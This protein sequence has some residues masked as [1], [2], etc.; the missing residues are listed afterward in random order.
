MS[1]GYKLAQ[2]EVTVATAGTA[3]QLRSPTSAGKWTHSVE[4]SANPT[5]GGNIYFGPST[6]SSTTIA[7]LA[8]GESVTL[9]G[10]LVNS[11]QTLMDLSEIFIDSDNDGESAFITFIVRVN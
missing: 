2:E 10:P 4:I 1:A 8:A 6:V 3:V 11:D 9:S 7:G 5:N